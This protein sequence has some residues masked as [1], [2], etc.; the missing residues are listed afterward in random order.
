MTT[1]NM[2]KKDKKVRVTGNIIR[3]EM[4]SPANDQLQIIELRVLCFECKLKI[5]HFVELSIYPVHYE[6]GIE[7]RIEKYIRCRAKMSNF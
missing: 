4:G 2:K 1:E 5:S 7:V 6:Y 3:T